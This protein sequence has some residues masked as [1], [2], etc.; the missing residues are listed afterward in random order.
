MAVGV[1][2]PARPGIFGQRPVLSG[3]A[4]ALCIAFSAVLVRLA[5]VEPATAAVFRCAYA[6]PV[7]YLLAARERRRY[8]PR[9]ARARRL[10][11]IAG[12]CFAVDLVLW[13]HAID[14]VGAGLGTVLG[15]LQVVVVGLAAWLLLG[16]RPGR[17]LVVAVPT[18]L[19]GVVLL[20][21]VVGEGAYGANP[22]LGAVFGIGTA[23]AYG[24]FLL[25]LRQ[26]NDD[27]RR[28]A[29]PLADATAVGA[30]A[31]ALLGALTGGVDLVPSWPG[32]GW[33]AVLALT[34]QVIG[35][36]LISVSLPRLPAAMTSVLLLLQ[37]VG[38]MVLGVILLGERPSAT[39]LLG[40][41]VILAGVV[42]ATT[43]RSR[44]RSAWGGRSL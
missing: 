22:A 12:I 17:G 28:P 11:M 29:G 34:S 8:G 2:P 4:G 42:L 15:N 20:S 6:L 36:L 19:L 30:V 1:A 18:V 16:E 44:R 27:L 3:V 40:A 14:A 41:G 43:A 23:L 26:G 21:G 13:H 38:S 7:L 35:W 9:A 25:I 33:L 39:Q 31:A 5:D 37:P 24:A 32:H 10:A